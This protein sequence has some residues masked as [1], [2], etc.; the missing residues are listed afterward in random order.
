MQCG[1]DFVKVD[2]KVP[3]GLE[4][5]D[6]TERCCS[7]DGDADRIVYFTV[8]AG[9]VD[10]H[11]LLMKGNQFVLMDGDKMAALIAGFLRDLLADLPDLE[12]LM[13]IGVVQTAYANGASTRYFERIV[14]F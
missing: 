13:D 2:Q 12:P 5:E 9:T 14:P 7:L 1:A 11:K 4:E 8:L 10:S 3:E 6:L